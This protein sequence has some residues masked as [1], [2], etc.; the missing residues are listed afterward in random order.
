MLVQFL[1]SPT[2][3]VMVVVPL[4]VS[5]PVPAK[6]ALAMARAWFT[7]TAPVPPRVPPLTCSARVEP[8]K[9]IGTFRLSVPLSRR[10]SPVPLIAETL[11]V[12]PLTTRVEALAMV[13]AK[14]LVP[15]LTIRVALLAMSTAPAAAPLPLSSDSD[16]ASTFR[17]PVL[18]K[19]TLVLKFWMAALVLSMVPVLL[20]VP[21]M[22]LLL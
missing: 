1:E 14:L 16:P 17:V 7:V 18:L 3:P 12:P 8:S 5:K 4:V 10:S 9:V 13:A 2:A 20:T 22:P 15:P 21:L 11:L 19:V 6:V